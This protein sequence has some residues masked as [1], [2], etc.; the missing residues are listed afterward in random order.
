VDVTTLTDAGIVRRVLAGDADAYALI[1]DRYYDRYARFA[2]H[3]VG[4]R[5]DAEEAL[6]DAFLRAY[7]ALDRYEEREK[8]G[9][10]LLRIVVNE[11]RTV[12]AR[13]RRRDLRFPDCDPAIW[14]AAM[15]AH[16]ADHPAELAALREELARALEQL[17]AEQREAVLLKYTEELS[18]DEI[19]AVTGAGTSALKMRVK[20]ACERLR[21]ILLGAACV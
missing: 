12:A 8:F 2:V 20:R 21:E 15:A 19:A 18:Y 10:W 9:G 6:Q 7:R 5:E 4:N 13:R 1:V 14:A 11:C 17:P 3:M 16:A